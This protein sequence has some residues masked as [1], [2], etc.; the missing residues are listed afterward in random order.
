MDR[1]AL[2]ERVALD[3]ANQR[4]AQWSL[5]PLK[6]PPPDQGD[7]GNLL[8]DA[9][10]A[11]AVIEPVVRA[12]EC[13]RIKNAIDGECAL[14]MSRASLHKKRAMEDLHRSEENHQDGR[15]HALNDISQF[16]AALTP[17]QPKEP[18]DAG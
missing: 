14:G 11:L 10:A 6:K 7:W 2:V 5:P 3:A 9:R 16:T 13:Q 17:P 8:E 12:A 15:W 4:R 1:D 18:T